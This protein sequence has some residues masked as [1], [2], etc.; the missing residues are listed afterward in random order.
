MSE[1][2]MKVSSNPHIRSKVSTSKIMLVVILG[3]LPTSIFG[4]WN[5][6]LHALLVI[7]TTIA[8]TVLTEL[9]Y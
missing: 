6:G 1:T 9:T 5:F 4:V 8:A 3:L 7:L 2:L